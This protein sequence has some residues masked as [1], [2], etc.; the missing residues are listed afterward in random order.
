MK[1]DFKQNFSIKIGKIENFEDL[2]NK[3]FPLSSKKKTKTTKTA[4]KITQ[5]TN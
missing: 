2:R 5:Q 1:L 3:S 4:R